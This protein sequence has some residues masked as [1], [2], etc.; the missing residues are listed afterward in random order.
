[1]AQHDTPLD[2]AFL[3]KHPRVA[4]FLKAHGGLT[5]KG[6]ENSK[7]NIIQKAW[8]KSRYRS[9]RRP[10]KSKE[11]LIIA[12]KAREDAKILAAILN[13]QS[14]W[15]KCLTS[16]RKNEETHGKRHRGLDGHEARSKTD[17]H[18]MGKW[19]RKR[20]TAARNPSNLKNLPDEGSHADLL[21]NIRDKPRCKKKFETE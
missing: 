7:A 19:L 14:W 17:A 16:R 8:S 4:S 20:A 1:M 5:R 9:N 10:C 13:I 6:V 3:G 11:S 15:R 12:E 2:Y 21:Y 18:L